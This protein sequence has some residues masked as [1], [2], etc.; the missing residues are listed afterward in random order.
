MKFQK[1]HLRTCGRT[2]KS[3]FLKLVSVPDFLSVI[4]SSGRTSLYSSFFLTSSPFFSLL[5]A[6]VFVFVVGEMKTIC[7]EVLPSTRSVGG[8]EGDA[9]AVKSRDNFLTRRRVSI[10]GRV[11]TCCRVDPVS[12]TETATRV[13]VDLRSDTSNDTD[14]LC[15]SI[16]GGD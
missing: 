12:L 3:V 1:P 7:G 11:L 15:S 2:S 4:F 14:L 9:S 16:I 13:G 10:G 5:S 6:L 8:G